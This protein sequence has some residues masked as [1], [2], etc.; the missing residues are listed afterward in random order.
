MIHKGEG[1][2]MHALTDILS[3]VVSRVL[4]SYGVYGVRARARAATLRGRLNEVAA[5]K[6]TRTFRSPCESWCSVLC[7]VDRR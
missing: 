1:G 3:I 4:P 6:R 7:R 5:A 2:S